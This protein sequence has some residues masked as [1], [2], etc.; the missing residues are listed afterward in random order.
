MNHLA[1]AVLDGSGG[2]LVAG[3]WCG[4]PD[5]AAPVPVEL[6]LVGKV[7]SN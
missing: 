3:A 5:Q 1:V 2:A 4:L 7:I 6:Q